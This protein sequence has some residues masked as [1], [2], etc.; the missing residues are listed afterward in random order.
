MF[1]VQVDTSFIERALGYISS[2][3]PTRL[4]EVLMH[5]AAE[6]VHSHATRFGNTEKELAEFW[7]ERLAAVT[8]DTAERA[9]ANVGYMA[10]N[11]EAFREAFNELTEYLP[12][13]LELRC[14]L[15]AVVGYDIGIVSDGDAY[16]NLAH[17][18]YADQRELVY[19]SMHELHHVAYTHYQPIYSLGGLRTTVD[20]RQAVMYSTHMEGLA[21]YA[22]Y[23]KRRREGGLN[24]LDYWLYEDKSKRERLIDEYFRIW[25]ELRCEP[26]RSLR[27]DDYGLLERLSGERLWYVTG[28]HMAETVDERLGRERLNETIAAGPASFYGAYESALR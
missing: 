9:R 23:A 11:A 6:G 14:H 20:L 1:S 7:E 26:L 22:A 2:P 25:D 19:F 27:E 16:L 5:P 15:Y 17:R 8:P 3:S 4:E 10:G 18:V 21:V 13:G 28:L 24:H 12:W